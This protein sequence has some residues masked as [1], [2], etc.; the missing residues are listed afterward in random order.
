MKRFL[1][2]RRKEQDAKLEVT[3]D[4]QD[5]TEN[6]SLEKGVDASDSVTTIAPAG[7]PVVYVTG[8]KLWSMLVAIAAVFILVLLDM[9]IVATVSTALTRKTK[10]S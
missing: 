7:E 5:S 4:V 2:T 9:S 3:A 10:Q 1:P 8:W 6:S